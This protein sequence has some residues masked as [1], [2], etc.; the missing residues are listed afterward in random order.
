MENCLV[1]KL[2]ADTNNNNLPFLDW[3]KVYF[4]SVESPTDKSQGIRGVTSSPKR[5]KVL[6]NLYFTDSTLIQNLGT[7]INNGISNFYVSNGEGVL[8]IPKNATSIVAVAGAG[9]VEKAYY[10]KLDE[11][12]DCETLTN[13]TIRNS[14]KSEGNIINLA[15]CVGLTDF[16]FG[17]TKVEG[18]LSE[19]AI[20]QI[21]KYGRTSGSLS[22][23][24]S[25]HILV[26]NTIFAVNNSL[27]TINYTDNTHFNIVA[28]TYTVSFTKSGGVWSYE[29]S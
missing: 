14:V 1:T 15:Q 20:A 10:I 28:T 3:Y 25:S 22:A 17:S 16:N 21:D 6:G 7:E 5:I 26:Y 11:F 8:L 9:E 12:A 24:A 2:K 13:V 23:Y 27:Y 19:F 18:N 4:K 29:R